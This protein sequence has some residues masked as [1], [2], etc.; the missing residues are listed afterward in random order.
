VR[1][2]T[3][4]GHWRVRWD[5]PKYNPDIEAGLIFETTRR[6]VRLFAVWGEAPGSFMMGRHWAAGRTV[7]G[8]HARTGWW[9][10][11]CLTL[12]AQAHPADDPWAMAAAEPYRPQYRV[13]VY[14]EPVR[15]MP[16]PP[17]G[18]YYLSAATRLAM[19]G[20]CRVC[21]AARAFRAVASE[22]IP[23]VPATAGL[24]DQ[25]YCPTCGWEDPGEPRKEHP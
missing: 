4:D 20:A 22:G 8:W 24:R 1:L 21:G 11:P 3:V 6:W 25:M 15:P 19:F 5:E 7:H 9:P 14:D 16:A 12:L 13:A 10:G 2:L 23:G 17:V 18:G